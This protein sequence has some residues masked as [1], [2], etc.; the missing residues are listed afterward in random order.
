LSPTLEI[1]AGFLESLLEECQRLL[2]TPSLFPANCSRVD[3]LTKVASLCPI[4][5]NI[6]EILEER[7]S[8]LQHI[9]NPDLANIELFGTDYPRD[10]P[11]KLSQLVPELPLFHPDRPD[12]K[13]PWNNWLDNSALA[14]DGWIAIQQKVPRIGHAMNLRKIYDYDALEEAAEAAEAVSSSAPS[15]S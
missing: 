13:N 12:A 5:A 6:E 11:E 14:A 10:D 9:L 15:I 3:F 1:I 8:S 7:D 4:I 2:A